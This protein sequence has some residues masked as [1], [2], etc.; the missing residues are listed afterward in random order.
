MALRDVSLY[1][2]A[3]RHSEART[4]AGRGAAYAIPLPESSERVVVRRNRHGGWFAPVTRDVFRS[5]TRAPLELEISAQLRAAGVPTPEILAYVTYPAALGFARVDVM[6]REIGNS[7]DLSAAFMSDDARE[8]E[9]G[10]R[11][12]AELITE[13]SAAGAR[14]HDLN[15][16]NVLLQADPAR[17]LSKA[18]VLDVDRVTFGQGQTATRDANLARL[19]RSARKWQSL[20]GARVTDAEL[21]ALDTMVRSATSP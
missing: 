8:R 13:L 15:I 5:P 1:E 19:L 6:S 4:L 7:S 2:F 18:F 14:H 16:K 3:S 11:A 10:L 17:R 21:E 12:T 9:I 20:Y